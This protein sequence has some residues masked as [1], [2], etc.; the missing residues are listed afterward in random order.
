ML[1]SFIAMVM[2]M[3]TEFAGWYNYTE[4]VESWGSIGFYFDA[5]LMMFL[6]LIVVLCLLYN[7]FISIMGIQ[8]TSY[9][10]TRGKLIIGMILAFIAFL[11][12]LIGWIVFEMEM[13][14]EDYSDWWVGPG[15]FGGLFGSLL[16]FIFILL[17]HREVSRMQAPPPG[18][19]PPPGPHG[20][21]GS[22]GP[23]RHDERSPPHHDR[24]HRPPRPP[25]GHDRPAR[26]SGGRGHDDDDENS[27]EED[28]WMR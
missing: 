21:P 9:E 27:D 5:P 24:S 22:H 11:M 25:P 23:P 15:F 26:D 10:P 4:T 18:A 1:T 2:L 3:T 8:T 13:Q 19:H 20:P 16:T 12:V 17:A 14:S 28:L 6:I 7:F